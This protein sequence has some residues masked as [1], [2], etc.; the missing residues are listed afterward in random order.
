MATGLPASRVKGLMICHLPTAW[1]WAIFEEESLYHEGKLE[2]GPSGTTHSL[3]ETSFHVAYA[4]NWRVEDATN[5]HIINGGNDLSPHLLRERDHRLFDSSCDADLVG[6]R[7][8]RCR[9]QI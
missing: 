8:R 4:M 7:N 5:Q 3:K 6:G 2:E 1:I 9:S